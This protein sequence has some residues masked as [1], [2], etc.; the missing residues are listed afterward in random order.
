VLIQLYDEGMPD[1]KNNY[2]DLLKSGGS[3]HYSEVLKPFNVDLKNKDSWQKGLSMISSLID[4][5]EKAI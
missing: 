3:K 1:F 2:I 4:E 5:F